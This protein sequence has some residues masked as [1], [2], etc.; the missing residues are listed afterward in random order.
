MQ[1]RIHARICSEFR[2]ICVVRNS[3][4]IYKEK[5]QV[6]LKQV[7]YH[8]CKMNHSAHL[9]QFLECTTHRKH[10]GIRVEKQNAGIYFTFSQ[11]GKQYRKTGVWKIS[12]GV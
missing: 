5:K 2:G 8:A 7:I 4:T 11:T 12:A 1:E 10:H 6:E 9:I 3:D